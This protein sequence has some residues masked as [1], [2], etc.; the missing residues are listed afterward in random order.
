M[1]GLVLDTGALIA[2]ERKDR[3]FMVMLSN[4]LE[5][6]VVPRVPAQVIAQYWRGG[7]GAQTPV[8]RLLNACYVEHLTIDQAK[9]AGVL[10][11]KSGTSDATDAVVAL[12]AARLGHVATSD[13]DDISHLLRTL[14]SPAKVLRV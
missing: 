13:P 5:L 7:A 8:S 2:I 4:T 11:G 9:D 14:N 3:R 10:L 12:F 1:D 6:G